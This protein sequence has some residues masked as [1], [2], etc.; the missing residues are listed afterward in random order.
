MP[1]ISIVETRNII[2]AIRKKYNYDFS[3]HALTHFRYRVDEVIS[4]HN[5]RY[6][7]I[8][9]NRILGDPEFFDDFLY[10]ISVPQTEIF[11][12]PEMWILLREKVFPELAS[13]AD[14]L[15][16]W[17]P[18]CNDGNDLTSLY[19]MLENTGMAR[20]TKFFA[21]TLSRKMITG[22]QDGEE[23]YNVQ[24]PEITLENCARVN[25]GIKNGTFKELAYPGS[26]Y[27]KTLLKNVTFFA[28][29]LDL[30][31]TLTGM[32]LIIFRNKLLAL[33]G[34]SQNLTLDKISDALRPGGFIVIGYRENIDDFLSK[35]DNL[36]VFDKDENIFRKQ[37]SH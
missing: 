15:N 34:E 32:D 18:D 26:R 6:S 31:P 27:R 29:D 14:P 19:F 11:R 37:K 24:L 23:L 13:L 21:S 1:A 30:N 36:E 17:F 20:K 12:D 5:I 8:L 22:L 33:T 7:E 28:Q 35:H 16:I 2:R 25:P 3:N 4:R 9:I 10:E